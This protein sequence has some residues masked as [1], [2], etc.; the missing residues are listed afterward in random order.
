METRIK[1]IV[2]SKY[3]DTDIDTIC[4]FFR[5]NINAVVEEFEVPN[6][7]KY[8]VI[9]SAVEGEV[10]NWI[11]IVNPIELKRLDKEKWVLPKVEGIDFTNEVKKIL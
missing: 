6:Q 4:I 1:N 2:N 8:M 5:N 9:V 11:E 10:P 3:L 7:Y